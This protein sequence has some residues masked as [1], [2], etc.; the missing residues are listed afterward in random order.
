MR[1]VAPSNL[2]KRPRLG[3]EEC[4]DSNPSGK[5]S[6]SGVHMPPFRISSIWVDIWYPPVIIDISGKVRLQ[7]GK[8]RLLDSERSFIEVPA[9]E[10]NL[11]IPYSKL[12][13]LNIWTKLKGNLNLEFLGV[14]FL[15]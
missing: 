1:I 12:T 7:I 9:R 14:D 5:L 15:I 10:V 3:S 8:G 4:G 2:T 11:S 13:K 6:G